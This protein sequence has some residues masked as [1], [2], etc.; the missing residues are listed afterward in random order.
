MKRNF[1]QLTMSRLIIHCKYVFFCF[2]LLNCTTSSLYSQPKGLIQAK[3][4]SVDEYKAG[5]QNWA[6]VQDKRGVMYFGNATGV[7][8]FDGENWKRTKMSNGSTVRSLAVGAKGEVFVGG[9]GEI[10][11]LLSNRT[12]S[13]VYH[14][15]MDKVDSAYSDFKEIWDIY[16]FGDTAFFLSD[17]F[18]FKYSNGHF[19]YIKTTGKSFYLSFS[20]NNSYYVQELGVGLMKYT[21]GKFK[22][23]KGGDYFSDI[24]IHSIF[25]RKDGFLVCTRKN[26]LFTLDTSLASDN[27]K[28]IEKLSAKATRIN[29]YFIKHSFYH[30]VKVS[31]DAYAFASISGDILILDNEWNIRDIIDSRTVGVKS[32]TLFLH[33]TDKHNLWLA[34]DNGICHVEAMSPYRYWNES[35]GI[36]G[37]LSDVACVGDYM[38]VSTG[39]GIFYTKVNPNEVELNY[40]SQVEGDFEQA[41]G[42]IYFQPPGAKKP[43]KTSRDEINFIPDNSTLLLVAT[44]TGL[45]QIDKAKSRKIASYDAVTCL[46]QSKIEPARLFLGLNKGIAELEYSKTGWKDNG[47]KYLR[48]ASINMLAED[49][50]GNIWAHVLMKGL[51]RISSLY[52]KTKEPMVQHLDTSY[53][54]PKTRYLQIYDV[55]NPVVFETDLG[56]YWFNDSTTR[57]EIYKPPIKKYTQEQKDYRKLDSLTGK[58]NEAAELTFYFVVYH[59]DSNSW[60]STKKGVFLRKKSPTRNLFNVPAV[61]IRNVTIGDSLLFGGANCSA[62]NYNFNDSLFYIDT[63]SVVDFN[64]VLHY[65]QNF[66]TFNYAWPYFEG[67]YKNEY[68]YFLEGDSKQWS[69]WTS[70]VKKEYTKLLE[71]NYT[72]KVKARNIYGI[73]SPI[74]EYK[75]SVLPPWYRTIY[76]YFGYFIGSVLLILLIVKLYTYRLILEKNK[77][78]QIVKERTQEILIQN[79]EILVQAEHLKDANDWISAKNLEL[80][81]RKEEIEKKNSELEISNATK[82]KFFRI[83]AH[84]LR[85]PIST[86]VNTTGYILTD[87]DD[88]DKQKTKKTIEEL[89]KLSLTTYNL[90]ENLLDWSTSQMGDITFNPQKLN[91]LFI[92]K[93]NVE[94]VKA[95]I[96]SKLINLSISVPAD[97][98]ILADENMLHT[99]IRNIITNAVKFTNNNGKITIAAKLHSDYCSLSIA[100][101]GVGISGDRLKKLFRID[102]DVVTVGTQNEKGSGLGLIL[103]KEFIERNGGAI[104]VESEPEKG[105][106]FTISLKLF[107]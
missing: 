84:D 4:Y 86:L 81:A 92:V 22:L 52:P 9:F 70:E 31:E 71:G 25:P 54:F 94:L 35:L 21:N 85:N 83:I 20:V 45:Y 77:L 46:Q 8:E 29:E 26:G 12:G 60:F 40:F 105:S 82:N 56:L 89:N 44:R 100:D 36:S 38:Y 49:S 63:S 1:N 42:F 18:I 97:I 16:C 43:V 98:E 23:I 79:E 17:K 101:T 68:S 80:E 62:S 59:R 64:T 7:L 5:T 55:H 32:P 58:R 107:K 2:L 33:S 91:L 72:F 103:S 69:N 10:G 47:I 19:D 90:L 51:Y 65:N 41:W 93:E 24:F 13:M 34:L 6:I 30:G 11:V 96:D 28:S 3:Y 102:K 27:V 106:I 73:E 95:K 99:V 53:G 57:F 88:F 104:T 37:I 61:I 15:L 14:S 66:I 48:N 74:A 75:F 50:V 87:I 67:G 76:A 39:S 78:E